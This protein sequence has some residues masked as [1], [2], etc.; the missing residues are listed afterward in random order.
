M[1]LTFLKKLKV[2]YYI[3]ISRPA[4]LY[5]TLSQKKKKKKKKPSK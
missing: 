3:V 1:I 4:Y 5:T 2:F